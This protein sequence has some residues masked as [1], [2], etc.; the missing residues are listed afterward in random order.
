MTWLEIAK[1]L[2]Q[3]QHT[4]TDCPQC[5]VSTNTNAAIVNHNAKYYSIYCNACDLQEYER[6][7]IQ[8]LE[9]RQR[10]NQLNE[11]AKQHLLGDIKLPEGTTYEP[12]E[13]SRE[14]RMW[15][16]KA[17]LTPTD[18][19]HYGIGYNERIERVI[20][21]V[22]DTVGKL[23]WYQCR[24]IITGQKPKYLQP[25]RDKGTIYYVSGTEEHKG[26]VV[27][28]EDVLSYI[29]V[30]NALNTLNGDTQVF[31]PLGTKLSTHQVNILSNYDSVIVWFDNDRAG[32]EGTKRIRQSVGMF[33]KVSSIR[34]DQDPKLYSSKQI[35]N[36]IGAK[37]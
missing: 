12:E 5:G 25:S 35:R 24:A 29:R 21:P 19:R 31:T 37:V 6:R 15:L 10:V 13:F 14:A 36:L 34:T 1:N 23:I 9:D 3:G 8:T 32:Q 16:Y 11:S 30:K 33:S 26:S 27:V 17:G 4:R 7:G 18:W 28:V 22:Y 20:L 2:P